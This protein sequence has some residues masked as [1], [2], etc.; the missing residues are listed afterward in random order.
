MP[1][2]TSRLPQ[3]VKILHEGGVI[4]CP[5]EAVWGLSC[6]PFNP[7]AVQRILDLKQRDP[8]KGLLLV[9][10]N[11]QAIAPLLAHLAPVLLE[12]L[13]AHWPGPF[14]FLIPDPQNWVPPYV[15]GNHPHV[16]VR[17]S[18]HPLVHR[19]CEAFG[20]PLVSTSANQQG[21][22][23][24]R[25]ETDLRNW[26]NTLENTADRPHILPGS[27]GGQTNPTRIID[28]MSGETVRPD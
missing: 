19:L 13:R 27:T 12:R 20:G 2:T 15:K 18:A 23:P 28:L 3:A 14:T 21:A 17:I 22:P 11:E 9:A 8:S 1:D 7:M 6:D 5:T 16:A 25:S 10:A 24:A 26:L 4:A